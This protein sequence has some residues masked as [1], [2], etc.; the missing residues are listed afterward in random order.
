MS[1][2][3]DAVD[4]AV[5]QMAATDREQAQAVA[6]AATAFYTTELE[7]LQA[8]ATAAQTQVTQLTSALAAATAAGSA[9]D[10]KVAALTEQLATS[11][12]QLAGVQAQLAA[13]QAA[14]DAYRKANPAKGPFPVG[15]LFVGASTQSA[16]TGIEALEKQL[17]VNVEVHRSYFVASQS[18]ASIAKEKAKA[19]LDHPY[20]VRAHEQVVHVQA[21]ANALATQ[22]AVDL[23]AGR[24]PMLSIKL[25]STWGNVASGAQ[26]AWLKA[27]LTALGLVQGPVGLCFHHEPFDDKGAAGSGMTSGD[28]VA[29][30][31]HAAALKAVNTYLVPILQSAPFDGTGASQGNILD[32]YSKTATDIAGIDCY[33]HWSVGKPDSA[34]RTPQQVAVCLSQ[35]AP[36][37]KPVAVAEWGVRTDPRTPGK[38]A[39]WM[40]DFI[41]YVLGQGAIF[42]SYFSSAQNVNDGGTPWVL[43]DERL[44]QMVKLVKAGA[45]LSA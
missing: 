10:A 31:E 38:A 15:N 23:K 17:G 3:S 33:N 21:A 5:G 16:E 7:E 24:F 25:P 37:G 2:I 27:L 11:N 41:T 19:H 32:W 1:T 26:D 4:A 34:W 18:V 22:A 43:A 30:Y 35:L 14:F 29:M 12:S 6:D 45:R 9:D 36:L 20:R 28:Y 44:A 42:A 13:L 39:Q 40:A 8:T